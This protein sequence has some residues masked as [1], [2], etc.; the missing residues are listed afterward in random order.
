MYLKITRG[1]TMKNFLVHGFNVK[2]PNKLTG[3]LNKYLPD[4]FMFNYGWRFFSVLWHNKQDAK[5]LK[6][7]L[8]SDLYS[9]VFAHSNGAAI[10]VEAARQGAFIKTLVCINPALKVKTRFPDNIGKVIIIHTRHDKPTRVA[11]F[12]DAVPLIGLLVPNAWGAMGAKGSSIK[13]SRIVNLELSHRLHGHS[14][15]FNDENLKL[16]M[17]EIKKML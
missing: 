11:A 14:D 6:R 1:M 13:D 3:K 17:P 8:N 15:F 7:Y 4:S 12:F 2:N 16:L 10:A 9:N 5:K